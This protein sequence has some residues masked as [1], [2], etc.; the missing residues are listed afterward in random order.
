MMKVLV[1]GSSGFVGR[2]L[3]DFLLNEG[4]MVRGL[5]EKERGFGPDPSPRNSYEE[6]I[7]DI[8]QKQVVRKAVQ[9]VDVVF[10][11]ASLVTQRDVPEE[12]YR[13]VNVGGTE[14]LLS[15]SK[16]ADVK[17]FI[18]CSTDSVVGKICH[19]P[20]KEVDT[21]HPE[22]IY[23]ATK[24]EAERRVLEYSGQM[25][26]VIVRPTRVYG[27]G[28]WRMLEIFK[29]IK[30]KTFFLVGKGEALFHPVYI[31]DCLQGFKL[32]LEVKEAEGE[33]FNIG[34]SEPVKIK[35]FLNVAAKE[36]GV[37]IRRIYFPHCL[38]KA[39]AVIL[40]KVCPAVGITPP[41]TRRNLEFFTKTRSY[42][43][44]RARRMLN[45]NP[46]VNVEEGIRKTVQ[47][48]KEKGYI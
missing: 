15:T 43:I 27:P 48:Y 9:D 1:T 28:D 5:D 34:G 37:R 18:Y 2:N 10:H 22:N 33:I 44:S 16:E 7:G 4:H 29:K 11:L 31:S 26:V 24:Y 46:G 42:D 30:S 19:P 8:T 45:Y 36:L 20:S 3:V 12:R 38:A 40:E 32:A 13:E 14:N 6:L 23:G 41:F 35:Y 25:S 39:I 47:W 17:R 21:P